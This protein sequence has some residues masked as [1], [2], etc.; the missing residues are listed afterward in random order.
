M[1]NE[2]IK[3]LLEL[4]TKAIKAEVK[5]TTDI[6]GYKIDGIIERQDV[7][8]HRVSKLEDRSELFDKHVCTTE[9]LWK[10][11]RWVAV[12]VFLVVFISASFSTWVYHNIDPAGTLAHKL[13]LVIKEK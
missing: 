1:R 2:D 8:N 10:N 5:S 6:L 4:H 11:R 13:G 9:K 3:E 7:A 12:A